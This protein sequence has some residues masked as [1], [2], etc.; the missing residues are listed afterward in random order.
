MSDLGPVFV[1]VI[2]FVLLTPGLLFQL[3]GKQRCVEFGNFQTSVYKKLIGNTEINQSKMYSPKF[4][5]SCWAKKQ[6]EEYYYSLYQKC[7]SVEEE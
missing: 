2:L 7:F 4:C 6:T 1:A 3:P 5:C